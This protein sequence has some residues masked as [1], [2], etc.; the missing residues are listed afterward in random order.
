MVLGETDIE[1]DEGT[2]PT[3]LITKE[4]A[5]AEEYVSV[6]V[7]PEAIGLLPKEIVHASTGSETE[8]VPGLTVGSALVTVPS[9]VTDELGD[10]DVEPAAATYPTP[11]M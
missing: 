7:E 9:Y 1:P 10:T 4:D 11:L 6:V 8:H 5:D 2:L 3:L